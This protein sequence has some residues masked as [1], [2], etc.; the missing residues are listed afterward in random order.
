LYARTN[1]AESNTKNA[2][3]PRVEPKTIARSIDL[4]SVSI[5]SKRSS[6]I[7][8]ENCYAEYNHN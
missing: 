4:A 3:H 5:F 1:I 7:K 2:K 8:K 6:V